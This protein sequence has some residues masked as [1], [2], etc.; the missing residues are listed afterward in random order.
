[1]IQV[2]KVITKPARAINEFGSHTEEGVTVWMADDVLTIG[3]DDDRGGRLTP[4]Q[5]I[6][7]AQLLMKAAECQTEYA[8]AAKELEDQKDKLNIKYKDMISGLG[9]ENPDLKAK[10]LTLAKQAWSGAISQ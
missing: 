2:G 6:D 8:K 1:M 9:L 4:K 5:A 3:F 7:L 10:D